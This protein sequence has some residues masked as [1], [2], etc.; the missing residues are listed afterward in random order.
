M[1]TYIES[2]SAFQIISRPEGFYVYCK[3][4]SLIIIGSISGVNFEKSWYAPLLNQL[5]ENKRIAEASMSKEQKEKI[6]QRAK[7][8]PNYI[9]GHHH[10]ILLKDL[11]NDIKTV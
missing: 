11:N 5:A 9:N 10:K 6:S 2:S 4:N 8:D 7:K 1:N 3:L